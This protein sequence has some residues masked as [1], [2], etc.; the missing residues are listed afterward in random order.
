MLQTLSENML[1]TIIDKGWP[2]LYFHERIAHS[3]E[4]WVQI[5]LLKNTW[6]AYQV[7][8]KVKKK[9]LKKGTIANKT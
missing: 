2:H 6:N 5:T 3:N 1:I 9:E 4:R 8:N 7:W